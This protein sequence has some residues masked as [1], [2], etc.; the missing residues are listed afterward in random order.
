MTFENMTVRARL[1]LA[2][3]T[4]TVM[5]MLVSPGRSTRRRMWSAC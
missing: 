4:L 2:F 1:A 5:V 3:G